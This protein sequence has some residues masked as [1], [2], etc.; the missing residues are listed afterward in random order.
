MKL[1]PQR[2]ESGQSARGQAEPVRSE[3]LQEVNERIR[4][5]GKPAEPPASWLEFVCECGGRRCGAL[6]RLTADEYD[7][8][9]LETG[10][11]L[12]VDHGPA[13]L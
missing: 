9:R 6:V 2:L 8:I 5:V 4:E 3:L 13:A 1:F 7:G 11:V 12:A 10:L